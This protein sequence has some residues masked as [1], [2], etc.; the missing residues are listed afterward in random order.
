MSAIY[1]CYSVNEKIYIFLWFWFIMVSVIT[2]VQ[3]IYRLVT[4]FVPKSREILLGRRSRL[5]PP[6][7]VS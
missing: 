1:N 3:L 7:D 5:L 4:I 6:Q 2:G